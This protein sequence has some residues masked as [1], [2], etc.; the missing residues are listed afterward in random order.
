VPVASGRHDHGVPSPGL[1]PF[2]AL[3]PP[4]R[5]STALW[6]QPPP[7]PT[8]SLNQQEN[9]SYHC[10]RCTRLSHEP[11]VLGRQFP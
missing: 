9:I 2:A 8:R 1:A 10:P 3:A 5:L 6:G 7:N 4:S 11:T